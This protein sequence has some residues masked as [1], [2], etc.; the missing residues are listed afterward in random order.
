MAATVYV[1][2]AAVSHNS[3]ASTTAVIDQVTVP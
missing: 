1:G 2:L 3:T